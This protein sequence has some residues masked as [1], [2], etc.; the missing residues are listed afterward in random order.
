MQHDHQV[1]ILKDL[2]NQLDTGT[3]CDSGVQ[4]KQ[5]TVSYID[6]DMAAKE[7][8][9]FF[10]DH[11]Q[12]IGLSGDL[13][14]PNSY[15]TINDFGIPVLATRDANGKF[16]AFV[17]ACRH[18]GAQVTQDSR[19]KRSHFVCPYHAWRYANDGS[20]ANIPMESQF[21]EFDKSCN[22][23]IELPA[24]EESGILWVHPKKD[25][26]INTAELLGDFYDD[27]AGHNFGDFI[28]VS[29][30]TIDKD[31]NWKLANDTFGET[32]HFKTLHSR[33]LS[34]LFY[35]D[36]LHFTVSGKNI[37]Q[38]F[39]RKAIDELR[40]KP[41]SEWNLIESAALLYYLFPN[42]QLIFG[43]GRM[44]LVKIYPDPE[45]PG[46]SRST[47]HSY[48]SQAMIDTLEQQ[49]LAE[50]NK[51]ATSGNVYQMGGTAGA[52]LTP[53]AIMEVFNSTIEDEDYAMGE[54]QQIAAESGLMEYSIFGRNEASLQHYHNTFRKALGLPPLEPVK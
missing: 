35:G 38:I 4:L 52:L 24:L 37:R 33:T 6:P 44:S 25:G 21:G 30:K 51:M 47:I 29:E 15:L 50:T 23:L 12:L 8:Q 9:I 18:R 2:L 1:R 53:E 13:P 3:T 49:R 48:F 46:R 31:L 22:G 34:N 10:Q 20:L 28:F 40:T 39:A 32:Y 7:W 26:E 27:I 54:S 43:P 45:N 41:E 17:N 14:E 36:N 42:I 19:G 5:P 16:R 11:P